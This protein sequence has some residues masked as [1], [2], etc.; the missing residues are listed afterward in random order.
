MAYESLDQMYDNILDP[1]RGWWDERQLSKV[2][3][4]SASSTVTAVTAGMVGHLDSSGEFRTGITTATN[5]LPLFARANYND[6]DV[7]GVTGNISGLSGSPDAIA[8]DQGLSTLVGTAAYELASSSFDSSDT[9][10]VGG[11]IGAHTT[12]GELVD[13]VDTD[14]QL[15]WITVSDAANYRGTDVVTFITSCWHV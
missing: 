12:S 1:I 11:A 6:N 3:K 5:Q 10:T 7:R 8:P 4:I 2:L 14:M 13:G 9:F 15:G